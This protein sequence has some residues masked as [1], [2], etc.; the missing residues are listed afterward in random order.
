MSREKEVL[1]YENTSSIIEKQ[2]VVEYIAHELSHQWFGNLVTHK[3]WT[4]FWLNEGIATF[5]QKYITDKVCDSCCDLFS[6][7]IEFY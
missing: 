6:I 2:T 5:F 7:N 1:F 3:W 4:Y